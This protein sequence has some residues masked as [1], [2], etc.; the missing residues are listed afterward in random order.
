MAKGLRSKTRKFWATERRKT[1]GVPVEKKQLEE[2]AA[3]LKA[4]L[5][6]Q[7]SE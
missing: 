5:D 3:R 4:S 2:Q 1:L 7:T 6:Q